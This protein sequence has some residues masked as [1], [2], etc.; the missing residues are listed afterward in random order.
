MATSE[1]SL[2]NL[3]L[4]KLGAARIVA[5]TENSRNAKSVNACYES[6]RNNELRK[7]LWNFA[8]KRVSLAASSVAPAFMYTSAFPLPSD[9]LRLIKPARLGLDWHI[10]QHDGG[11]AI[12]TNDGA[13]LEVRYLAIVTNPALFDPCFVEMLACKIAWHCCED[14]TQSNTKKAA[15]MEEYMQHRAEARKTNAFELPKNPEPV[16]EWLVARHSGQLV[17]TEWDEE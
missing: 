5:L 10:E 4:Q 7:H 8:R 9:F 3:A 12:L 17:N 11:V 14:L 15:L 6:Q 16:D 13:P 1:V 2:C